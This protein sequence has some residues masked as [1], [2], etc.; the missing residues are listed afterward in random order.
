MSLRSAS[1]AHAENAER[2]GGTIRRKLIARNALGF[3]LG[4]W[5]SPPLA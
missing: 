1:S 4:P 2:Q 5:N 3:A